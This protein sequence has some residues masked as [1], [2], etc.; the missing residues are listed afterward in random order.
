MGKLDAKVAIVTGGAR[1]LGRAYARRLAA[2]GAK[3]AICDLSL[4]SFEEFE[5]ESRDM[6]GDSTVAEIE[7]AGGSAF[8]V[9]LDV[10]DRAA[11]DAMVTQVAEKWGRVDILVANAG[12]GR[13][14]P[15]DTKAS[16]LDTGLLDLVLHM[17]LYGT[18]YCCNAV[19]PIMKQQ[20]YHCKLHRPGDD[21][22]RT[23]HADRH[24]GKLRSQYRPSGARRPA[25]PRYGRG[26]RPRRGI[27]DDR[28]IGLC[29]GDN[30]PHRWRIDAVVASGR[31]R[32][33]Q[34]VCSNR[35]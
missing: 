7:A 4:K 9:E 24:S 32:G 26:L 21:R 22:Y 20:R 35:V 11:V 17:N 23:D 2:L 18:I 15:L 30:Y 34:T 5:A 19:A 27:P 16:T 33:S 12:G 28:S 3:I 14:R 1:G 8:G 31:C 13:G 25:A 29:D 10:A 6:T